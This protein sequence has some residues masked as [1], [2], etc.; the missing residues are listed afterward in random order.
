MR[1]GKWSLKCLSSGKYE[2]LDAFMASRSE[3]L[4]HD[5]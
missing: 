5:D 3:V 4:V 1:K 2:K